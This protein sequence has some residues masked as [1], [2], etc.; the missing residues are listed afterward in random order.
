MGKG[1]DILIVGAGPVGLSAAVALRQMGISIRIIDKLPSPIHESRAAVMHART[2]EHFERLGIVDDFLAAGVKIDGVGVYGED[3][4]P[5]IEPSFARLP[6]AYPFILGIEQFMTE[7][8]LRMRLNGV[9]IEREVEF[10]E[11]KTAEV[12]NCGPKNC[13]QGLSGFQNQPSSWVDFGESNDR[14]SAVLQYPNGSRSTEDFA[15]ILGADG[16][17]S[18]VRAAL[19]IPLQGN[20]LDTTWITVDVKIRWHRAPGRATALLSNNGIIFAV[21]INN[22]RWRVVVNFHK[23]SRQE[24]EKMT[25][26]DVEAIVRKRFKMDISFY[27]PLWISPFGVSTRLVSAMQCGRVFLAGDAAHV[28][29]PVGGQ[30]MNMGI[31]DA[32]NLAWKLAMVLQGIATPELLKSY[33]LER[34]ANA[35]RILSGIRLATAMA[36]FRHPFAILLRN[37]MIR[38]SGK[39]GLSRR[40]P[41]AVSMLDVSYLKSPIV[42]ESNISWLARGP[43]PGERAPDAKNLLCGQR[44]G[45]QRLSS[46][47]RND[48]RHQ[49]LIFGNQKDIRFSPS[50]LYSITHI[51]RQ[52]SPKQGVAVD[53]KGEAYTAYAVTRPGAYYLVRPDGF[54][55]FRSGRSDP[56]ALSDYLR[57]WYRMKSAI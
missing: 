12:S 41:Y 36:N 8:L 32:L 51:V 26:Q 57:R 25:I 9:E 24:A 31:Q 47:W 7:Q 13:K 55:A 54:I 2:L 19:C 22:N 38:F 4:V 20:L 16:A 42:A 18:Q 14:V 21:P 37:Q 46:L 49:L 39:L 52:G 3:E 33:H 44:S 53:T 6:T 27:D 1:A 10:V 17:H 43:R 56:R 23:M 28:H 11:L 29:S 30:G 45:L 50:S 15:Y 35:K 34:Y 48:H 40:L 5:L